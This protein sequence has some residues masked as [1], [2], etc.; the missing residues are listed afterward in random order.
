V[1]PKIIHLRDAPKDWKQLSEYVYIGRSDSDYG[2][3]GN[4]YILDKNDPL[5]REKV[6]LQYHDYLAKRILPGEMDMAFRLKVK[7]LYGKTLVCYCSPLPCH[8]DILYLYAEY[9]NKIAEDMTEAREVMT[10]ICQHKHQL[11]EAKHIKATQERAK[12]IT[13]K[14][15]ERAREELV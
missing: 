7:E 3:F 5:S 13:D 14:W 11:G 2:I 12:R 9:L 6:L 10:R 15:A 4:P 8:G 1:N